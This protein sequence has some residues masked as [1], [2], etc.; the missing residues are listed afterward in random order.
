MQSQK[1]RKFIMAESEILKIL[2]IMSDSCENFKTLTSGGLVF[3]N[4]ELLKNGDKVKFTEKGCNDA[5]HYGYLIWNKDYCGFE[6]WEY[7]TEDIYEI[8]NVIFEKSNWED[9]FEGK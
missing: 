6:I 9:A 5:I 1:E 3:H 7:G 4:G 8:V 2:A